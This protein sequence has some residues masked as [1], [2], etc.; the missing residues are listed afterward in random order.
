VSKQIKNTA[1]RQQVK[2]WAKF[3]W[4][5]KQQFSWYAKEMMSEEFIFFYIIRLN[6]MAEQRVGE[7]KG[8]G[9]KQAGRRWK[10]GFRNFSP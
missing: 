1:P 2:I 10:D 4:K 8:E 3:N 7:G 5:M 6:Q 9:K